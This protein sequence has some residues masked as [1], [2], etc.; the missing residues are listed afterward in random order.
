MIRPA[1]EADLP[2]IRRIIIGAF[3]KDTIHYLLEEKYGVLGGKSWEDRKAEEIE[4]YYRQHP[5]RVLVTELEGK[6]LGFASFS[7]DKERKMGVVENN[8]VDPGYQNRGIGTA[9][10][11]RV[12]EIFREMGMQLAEVVTGL[13]SG[14]TPARRMYEKCGFEPTQERIIYHLSLSRA[15]SPK[16]LNSDSPPST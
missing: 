11:E 1:T 16:Y 2:E 15:H 9:Q 8:A 4:S 5:N 12:L 10:I 14:Y 7:V 6:L 3:G 13:D